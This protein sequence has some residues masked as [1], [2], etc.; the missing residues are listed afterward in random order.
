MSIAAADKTMN[1]AHVFEFFQMFLSESFNES[2][3]YI[4]DDIY[5]I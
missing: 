5:R 2:I 4:I 1:A 3:M